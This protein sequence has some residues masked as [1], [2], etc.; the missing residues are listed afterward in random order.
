MTEQPTIDASRPGLLRWQLSL[1][2]SLAEHHLAGCTQE[3]LLWEPVPGCA[4][5]RPDTTGRWWPDW[6]DE[7]PDALPGVSAG[8][9]SWHLG[10]WWSE[11]LDHVAGRVPVPRAEVSWPGSAEAAAEWL[12]ALHGRW[13]DHLASLADDDLDRPFDFPWPQP[14]PFAIA[15]AW[16]NSELMKNVSEIGQLRHTWLA[17]GRPGPE[18]ETARSVGG[19]GALRPDRVRGEH[20]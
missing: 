8:W 9:I 16:V 5:V 13:S 4:S 3:F 6:N 18:V 20:P 15:A 17:L 19:A 1:T 2:W 14:R 12:R 10:W 7:D 11:T